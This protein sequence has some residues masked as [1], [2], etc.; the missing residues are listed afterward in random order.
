LSRDLLSTIDKVTQRPAAS[1]RAK[2]ARVDEES[3]RWLR[4]GGEM[5]ALMRSRDWSNTVLGP[6]EGWPLSLQVSAG[7]CVSS[8][9]DLI[10]WWGPD[11]VMLYNDSYRRTL[12]RK[13][14][15]ALGR[16]GREVYAE[17]WDVIGPML[18]QVLATGEATWSDDLMLL[19]ERN[20]YPE[21]T[22]HTF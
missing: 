21:E 16:P 22:Y 7:I 3:P 1:A 10:V 19:L 8:G 17:I 14:P 20:G 2:E 6:V 5:G 4:G 18:E 15:G 11:L 12:G 13:H 9:F